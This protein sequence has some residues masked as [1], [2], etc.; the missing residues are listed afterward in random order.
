M[1]YSARLPFIPRITLELDSILMS[2]L[3]MRKVMLRKFL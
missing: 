3:E 1:F 2:I